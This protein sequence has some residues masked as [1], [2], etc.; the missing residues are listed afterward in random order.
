MNTKIIVLLLALLVAYLLFDNQQQQSLWQQEQVKIQDSVQQLQEVVI[1]QDSDLVSKQKVVMDETRTQTKILQDQLKASEKQSELI[2]QQL[3]ETMKQ[4]SAIDKQITTLDTVVEDLAM[5]QLQEKQMQAE[6]GVLQNRALQASYRASG[7]QTGSMIKLYVTEYYM[8]E[9]RFP[10]SNSKLKLP[11]PESYANDRVKSITVS[12]GGRI[13]IV[14]TAKSGI[15]GGAIV[16]SPR[17]RNHQLVWQCTSRDFEDI[18][19]TLP[20][21]FYGG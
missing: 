2:N 16:L 15:D 5:Q 20:A 3:Q 11:R 10:D 17:E 18:Q 19:D 8:M 14:Y 1:S 6:Y 21:C 12:K 9:G 4:S 13:T 7:L